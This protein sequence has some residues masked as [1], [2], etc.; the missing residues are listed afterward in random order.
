MNKSILIIG[1]GPGFS[2]GVAE[3]FGSEGY[4]VGLVSRNAE[5]LQ[6]L[7]DQLSRKG[8]TNYYAV[9]DASIQSELE[10]AITDL[11]TKLGGVSVLLYNAAALK[12]K[13]I[14]TET[15]DDLVQDFKLNVAHAL[16]SAQI[17]HDDLK[18]NQGAILLTGG[19]LSKNPN[20]QYGSLALGK[21]G[22]LNL[23]LQL[24]KRLKADGIFAGTI[25]INGFIRPFS[26]THSPEILAEKLWRLFQNRTDAEV[27]H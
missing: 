25:T 13:D 24:N 7:S 27:Q 6:S 1:A 21:A 18:N 8:I 9:A 14:W 23:A 22:T 15:T 11:K 20:P 26:P 10:H 12:N 2:T 5:K 19:G 16:Y 4:S 17:L 3:K